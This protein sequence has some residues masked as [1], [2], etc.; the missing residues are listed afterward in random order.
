MGKKSCI[1]FIFFN[2]VIIFVGTETIFSFYTGVVILAGSPVCSQ[3]K[4]EGLTAELYMRSGEH[5]HP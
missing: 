3:E 1:Y 2:F 5:E 4:P